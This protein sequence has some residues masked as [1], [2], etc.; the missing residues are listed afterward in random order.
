MKRQPFAP[1][2]IRLI[3]ELQREAAIA[4]LR[5]MPLDAEKPLE[6]MFREEVK[7]RKPDQNAL[8]WA[9]PLRDIA[10]QGYVDGRSYTAEVWHEHFKA[11]FLP[12]VFEPELC[13]E[14]YR[15]YDYTP[16]GKRVLIG[17]T[18]QLTVKGFALY[19]QQVEAFGASLGVLFHVNPNESRR[20]A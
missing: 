19:L 9:G 2:K 13:K 18:T 8:M 17:S 7:A 6:A 1:R 12:E 11:E 5:N 14:G 20:A 15:K 10:E 16:S 3:G 4:V